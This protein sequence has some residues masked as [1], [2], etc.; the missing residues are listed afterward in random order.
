[1]R[2]D[3][4]WLLASTAALL[5]CVNQWL[6]V[7]GIH[8]LTAL[9]VLLLLATTLLCA[10]S[11][12]T[13]RHLPAICFL[14]LFGFPEYSADPYLPGYVAP[15]GLAKIPAL[16]SMLMMLRFHISIHGL[17]VAFFMAISTAGAILVGRFGDWYAE[18][19]YAALLLLA[20]NSSSPL[21]THAKT[22]W[23][24]AFER[25]FYLLLPMALFSSLTG[26]FEQRSAD[27][28]TYFYGHWI[29][30]VSAIAIYRTAT[31]ES[32]IL[33][34]NTVRLTLLVITIYICAASYQSAH[35]I[36]MG[37]AILFAVG[38]NL[39]SRV[40]STTILGSLALLV[41]LPIAGFLVLS[42]AG[43]DSWLY[44]KVSQVVSL[45]SGEFLEAS[46]SQLLSLFE[47][48]DPISIAIGRGVASTYVP[49]G[50]LWDFVVFHE[51]TYPEQ[52]LVSGQ[53]QYIHESITML[54]KWVGI[55]GLAFIFYSV[56][57]RLRKS[58][59]LKS[60]DG[61]IALMFLL[62]FA[63]SLHTGI[64]TTLLY[65]FTARASKVTIRS[66]E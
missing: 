25:L 62:L 20:L 35:F 48:S 64:I 32:Y 1:M 55:C 7:R 14:C 33:T 9:F 23:L 29:G 22:A 10:F 63:S 43:T 54:I 5:Y 40:S 53:L 58:G 45:A 50:A 24:R 21:A 27:T 18:M 47:Q 49:E 57:T 19:W 6:A 16:L 12:R 41:S 2:L 37:A 42:N 61:L 17:V 4:N 51:A 44:L 26:L 36:L 30:I 38:K 11:E 13:R 39:T 65:I 60:I 8:A 28:T 31:G 52:E 3:S 46:N 59:S 34:N 56:Y 66:T 15:F